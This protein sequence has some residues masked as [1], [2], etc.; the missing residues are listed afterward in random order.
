MPPPLVRRDGGLTPC[1]FRH[2]I[3]AVRLALEGPVDADAEVVVELVDELLLPHAAIAR[4]AVT[5]PSAGIS[6]RAR[7]RELLEGFMSGPFMVGLL[8]RRS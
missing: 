3:S 2:W 5:A 6:R 7:R 8:S 4:L 1:F